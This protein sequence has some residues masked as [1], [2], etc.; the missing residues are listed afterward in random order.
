M[1]YSLVII[2]MLNYAINFYS[3]YQ[4]IYPEFHLLIDQ[5]SDLGLKS[6]DLVNN[7]LALSRYFKYYKAIINK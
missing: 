1:N 3:Y 6:F 2:S 4:E 5:N 7:T